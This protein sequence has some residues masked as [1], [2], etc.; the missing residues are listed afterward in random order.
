MQIT[1]VLDLPASNPTDQEHTKLIKAQLSYPIKQCRYCGFA[2]VVKNGFRKAHVRLQSLNGIR[3][4]LELW[5]Q[6]YYCRQCQTTFGATTNLTT[7]NQTLSGQLKNQ[8]MEFVKEGLNGKLIARVCHC[9]PSSVRRTIKERVKPHYR[10]AKLPHNLCFDEF[11]SVK[12]TMSFICCDSENHQLVAT[13]HDQLSPSIIDYFENRYS[14]KE[15]AQVKTVVIDLNAQYQSFIYRLFPNA[16]IIIDRFHIVQLVGRA[17]DNCRVNIL[18]LLDKHTREYK[19][20]KSQWKLFHLKATELQPEKPVYLR[21]INEYMT[22]QNAVDLVLNQFPQFSAVYTAYQE[23]TAALQERDSERLIT[24]LSQYQNTG[25]EMD[26]A[27][28]TLNKNQS[29]VINSTQFEFSNGP[30]EGINRRI[31][32]L[33][34]SCYGFANQQFFFLRIDCLFA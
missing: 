13:L 22:K 33:K 15:R 19:L 14:K 11:R 27:I 30:L 10:M 26:T 31:K 6:R 25:T 4:E 3:Y 34:R 18:K 5:K 16:R 2:A 24:I 32:T 1:D 8:I 21:G 9:S 28:A 12:S 20:L 23:I 7:N 29:Y 17:L